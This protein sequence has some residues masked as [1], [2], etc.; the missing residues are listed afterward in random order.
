MSSERIQPTWS[1]WSRGIMSLTRKS[2]WSEPRRKCTRPRQHRGS[3]S[4]MRQVAMLGYIAA[5]RTMVSEYESTLQRILSCYVR[6]CIVLKPEIVGLLITVTHPYR[7]GIGV[8][9]FGRQ[10][11]VRQRDNI[12]YFL[13]P[14]THR[15]CD[16]AVELSRVSGVNEPVG[17]VVSYSCEFNTPNDQSKLRRDSTRQLRRVGVGG[18]YFG[19]SFRL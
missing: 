15:R 10:D 18:V 14:N 5:W 16:S 3:S 2:R 12:S 17:I 19:L 7:T 6:F 1:G 8:R 9:P 13:M 4:R 11:V